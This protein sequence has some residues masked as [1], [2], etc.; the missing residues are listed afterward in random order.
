MLTIW[1]TTVGNSYLSDDGA[2][3]R[4]AGRQVDMSV[5]KTA[6]E[7]CLDYDPKSVKK[8]NIS[9]RKNVNADP[10]IEKFSGLRIR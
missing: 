8:E 5:F 3:K 1:L 10:E 9:N 6:V 4:R 7:D 2:Q